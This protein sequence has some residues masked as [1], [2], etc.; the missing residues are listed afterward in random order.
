LLPPQ[1][2]KTA[3]AAPIQV[4]VK[5]IVFFIL[6]SVGFGFEDNWDPL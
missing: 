3:V 1:M 4:L 5:Q 6:S 2:H